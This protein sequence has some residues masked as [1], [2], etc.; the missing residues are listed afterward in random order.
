MS[1]QAVPTG[2]SVYPYANLPNRFSLL[3][4]STGKYFG[5]NSS[6]REATLTSTGSWGNL[7]FDQPSGIYG[8]TGPTNFMRISV[9]G[10]VLTE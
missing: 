10:T 5:F 1:V 7:S 3:A 8:G 4:I 9:A 2:Y 6:T